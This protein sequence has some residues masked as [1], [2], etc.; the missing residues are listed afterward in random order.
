MHSWNQLE[1]NS[2]RLPVS[3][4]PEWAQ[5]YVCDTCGRDVTRF[6]RRNW[7]SHQGPPLGPETQTCVCGRVYKTGFVEW[8]HLTLREQQRRSGGTLL[9]YIA[10]VLVFGFPGV[11]IGWLS[12][13]TLGNWKV[14]FLGT[15]LVAVG[16]ATYINLKWR[17]KIRSSQ[18]RTASAEVSISQQS[19]K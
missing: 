14:G 5:V 10:L 16:W 19:I 1:L 9:I 4:F 17:F 2:V 8:E 6:M 13:V 12:Y 11:A 7:S 3:K 18:R 15:L